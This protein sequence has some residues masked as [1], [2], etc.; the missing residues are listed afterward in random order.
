[1]A[2]TKQT[3]RNSMGGKAPKKQLVKKEP[4]IS[5][6]ATASLSGKGH[7]LVNTLN[8][9]YPNAKYTSIHLD[10]CI[11]TRL[12]KDPFDPSYVHSLH[13]P[14]NSTGGNG[15][16]YVHR[17]RTLFAKENRQSS[18]KIFN[19]LTELKDPVQR[20]LFDGAAG[21]NYVNGVQCINGIWRYHSDIAHSAF[22]ELP[23]DSPT[24]L[25]PGILKG[26]ETVQ[27]CLRIVGSF[28]EIDPCK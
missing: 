1:M 26:L 8:W 13:G 14:I 20:N 4:R 18:A 10:A 21:A 7:C 12:I 17:V 23:Q 19:V 15:G 9:L 2:R 27:V 25:A 16:F 11:N 28:E 6:P 3:A 5:A 24:S 22:C